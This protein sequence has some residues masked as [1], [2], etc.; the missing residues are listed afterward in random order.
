MSRDKSPKISGILCASCLLAVA[1]VA[2]SAQT[3]AA[4]GFDTGPANVAQSNSCSATPSDRA[5]AAKRETEDLEKARLIEALRH[6]NLRM[7]AQS[8]EVKKLGQQV[9]TP[10]PATSPAQES[11]EQQHP[12]WY[13]E[14]N[15]YKPC[16]WNMCPSPPPQ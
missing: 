6:S 1:A 2:L 12:R 10:A 7:Q 8:Q 5:A 3:A 11:T 13:R 15:K 14:T 9:E 4:A 16:P